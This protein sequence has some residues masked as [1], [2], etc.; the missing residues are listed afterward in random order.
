MDIFVYALF[1]QPHCQCHH[2]R[3]SL[4]PSPT[5]P[6]AGFLTGI[7]SIIPFST[8]RPPWQG[9][10]RA[11]QRGREWLSPPC[12]FSVPL[13]KPDLALG[14]RGLLVTQGCF[15]WPRDRCQ[16]VRGKVSGRQRGRKLRPGWT[17]SRTVGRIR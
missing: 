5:C 10:K 14:L 11:R 3:S 12:S 1:Y 6:K 8:C 7:F 17:R 15:Q 16:R 13:P 9:R 2:G 4:L